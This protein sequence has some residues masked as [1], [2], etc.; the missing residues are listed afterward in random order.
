MNTQH[1]CYFLF[2]FIYFLFLNNK[3]TNPAVECS[4]GVEFI[5]FTQVLEKN[6][7]YRFLLF[8]WDLMITFVKICL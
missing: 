3:N 5:L 2:I 1:S 4:E 8:N 6:A 7:W